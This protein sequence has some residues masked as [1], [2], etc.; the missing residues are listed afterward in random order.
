MSDAQTFIALCQ[1]IDALTDRIA[2]HDA[3]IKLMKAYI[4]ALMRDNHVTDANGYELMS[5]DPRRRPEWA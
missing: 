2:E 3:D 1:V 4:A 5:D